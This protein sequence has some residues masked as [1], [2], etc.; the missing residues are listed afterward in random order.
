MQLFVLFWAFFVLFCFLPQ[1]MRM[2]VPCPGIEPVPPAVEARWRGP[3]DCQGSPAHAALKVIRTPGEHGYRKHLQ[4]GALQP[5]PDSGNSAAALHSVSSV[6]PALAVLASWAGHHHDGFNDRPGQSRPG[7]KRL[8]QQ[9]L[10][11]V[12]H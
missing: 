5:H 7:T 2:L 10:H 6:P 4:E 3:L 1:T 8:G 11:G 12:G 9:A